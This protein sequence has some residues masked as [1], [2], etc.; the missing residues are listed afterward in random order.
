V[1]QPTTTV[2]RTA[3]ADE[4]V[5]GEGGQW[6]AEEADEFIR[7]VHQVFPGTRELTKEAARPGSRS[8]Q[9]RHFRNPAVAPCWT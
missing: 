7:L 8:H 3:P 5:V 4:I 2:Q 1:D 9:P 6:D